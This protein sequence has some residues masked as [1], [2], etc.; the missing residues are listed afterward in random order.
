MMK[1]GG[2]AVASV[3]RIR[4]VARDIVAKHTALESIASTDGGSLNQ[5]VVVVSAIKGVTDDLIQVCDSIMMGER[6]KVD[7][8]IHNIEEKHK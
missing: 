5:I 6:S 4:H 1:F 2:N 8:I 7:S 3:E